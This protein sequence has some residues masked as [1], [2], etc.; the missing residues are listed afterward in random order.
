M[1]RE[2]DF[3]EVITVFPFDEGK[4]ARLSGK[5][6]HDDPYAAPNV[7]KTYE[8]ESRAWKAGFLDVD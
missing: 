4:E 7:S 1:K 8:V 3:L 5:N 2:T 6:I